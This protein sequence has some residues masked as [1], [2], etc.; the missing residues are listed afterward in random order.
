MPTPS[1]PVDS[2]IYQLKVTLKGIKPPIWRQIQV[3]GDVTLYRLHRILQVVM[4][5]GEEHLYQFVLRGDFGRV[6]YGEPDLDYDGEMKSARRVRLSTVAPQEKAKLIYEYDFGDGWEHELLVEKI[7]P[8]A[9][10]MSYPRCLAGRRACPPEDSGGIPGYAELL[11]T[12]ADPNN[13]E[14]ATMLEWLGGSFDPEEFD[15]A[16]VNRRLGSSSFRQH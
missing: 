16:T 6:F 9:A 14:H 8:R 7:L 3:P 1:K 2:P 5:W 15:L 10:E 13:P 11:E 12:I 4:G